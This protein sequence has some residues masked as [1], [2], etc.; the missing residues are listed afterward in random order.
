MTKLQSD[1]DAGPSL[2]A[3]SCGARESGHRMDRGMLCPCRH[4]GHAACW[5]PLRAL[6]DTP[7]VKIPGSEL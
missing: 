3:V 6:S 2:T 7:L 1:V 5:K 4:G